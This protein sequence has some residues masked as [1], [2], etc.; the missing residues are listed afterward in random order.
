MS[1]VSYTS[2]I[3]SSW[4]G[5]FLQAVDTAERSKEPIEKNNLDFDRVYRVLGKCFDPKSTAESLEKLLS[6]VDICMLRHL[7]SRIETTAATLSEQNAPPVQTNV[8]RM[9]AVDSPA[10]AHK[11]GL[12]RFPSRTEVSAEGDFGQIAQQLVCIPDGNKLRFRPND[13]ISNLDDAAAS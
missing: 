3:S 5:A 4:F 6:P 11:G 10:S 9:K 2:P 8:S 7:L 13:L 12:E 1:T